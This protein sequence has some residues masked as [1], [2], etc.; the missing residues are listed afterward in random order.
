[1]TGSKTRRRT[2]N[3]TTTQVPRGASLDF[4]LV[5]AVLVL[6]T[7]GLT[8]VY[9]SSSTYAAR[10]F[11]DPEHFIRL[12]MVRCAVGLI[13]LG[14]AVYLPRRWLVDRPGWILLVSVLLCVL[15]LIPGLG[16]FR[17]G[18]RRWLALGPMIFQ[19]SE[20]AKLGIIVVLAAILARRDAKPLKEQP[21]LLFPVLLV[22]IPVALILAEPDLGTALV[23]EM[24]MVIMVFVAG[25]RLRTLMLLGLAALPVF[26][27][28]VVGTPFRLRRL[29]GY[30]DPWAYRQ[31]VGY[32]VTEA[33]IS[34][35]S[36]G[37]SGL[38]LGEGK[39]SLFFLPEAHTDFIFAILGQELG[40]IGV[41]LLIGTFALFIWRAGRLALLAPSSFDRY[42]AL[43]I[44]AL[45]GVPAV[46]NMCVVTG[47]LP[48]KGLPLPLVSYGGSNLIISLIGIGLLIRIGRDTAATA[49]SARRAS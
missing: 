46:F 35:G 33:L 29:L 42:L 25:V 13:A 12:Q 19:P 10:V 48:T 47:L 36:G 39:H 49:L 34:M 28:L 4:G 1:M 9:S 22:Q 38:G 45:I 18:A 20:I 16:I 14:L 5:V 6:L 32:Q 17:G 37:I 30:I 11:Q 40:L 26:Y 43:G 7:L 8:M 41:L 15:V 3:R 27:H 23:I 21:S 31:T 44:T 24:I 2:T